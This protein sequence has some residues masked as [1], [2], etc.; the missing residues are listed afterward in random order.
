M[1]DRSIYWGD[2]DLSVHAGERYLHGEGGLF[3]DATIVFVGGEGPV[4]FDIELES[5][6]ALPFAS[7]CDGIATTGY[8]GVFVDTVVYQ[9]ADLTIEACTLPAGAYTQGSSVNYYA[10][11]SSADGFVYH[12]EFSGFDD[13][14]DGHRGGYV[15][16]SRVTAGDTNYTTVP[17]ARVSGPIE[18]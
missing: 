15:A 11:Q 17:F 6:E 8:V 5:G 4:E 3:T 9:D 16:A 14:C 12:V 10:A 7:S 18:L 13:L 1:G 2:I